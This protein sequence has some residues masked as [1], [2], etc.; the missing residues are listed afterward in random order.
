MNSLSSC[1]SDT[2]DDKNAYQQRLLENLIFNE[3]LARN[4]LVDVG[5]ITVF[6]KCEQKWRRQ[7]LEISFVVHKFS[8]RYYLKVASRNSVGD[9]YKNEKSCL[10]AIRDFFKK[11]IITTDTVLPYQDEKGLIFIGLEDFILDK[12]SLN[13]F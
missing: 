11:L 6:K 9:Y 2:D 10:C 12:N 8:R 7:K 13:I 1:D 4:I 3:L 5:E